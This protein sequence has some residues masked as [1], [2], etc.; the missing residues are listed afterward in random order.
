MTWSFVRL[1]QTQLRSSV[2]EKAVA[3]QLEAGETSAGY[4]GW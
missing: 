2:G 4:T 3:E 1:L